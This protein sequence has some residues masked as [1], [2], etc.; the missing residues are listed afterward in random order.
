MKGEVGSSLQA[1]IEI[2]ATQDSFDRITL[3]G[4][5]LKFILIVSQVT[6]ILSH[7]VA[8]EF[9]FGVRA[10]R[11]QRAK[12][13]RCWH[14]RDD[15]GIDPAHPTICGRCMSNLYGAGEHRTVA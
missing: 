10:L 4:D 15:V 2:T 14:Y 9:D 12:C 13:E 7:E 6:L 11:S 1:E 8:D 3:L 5:D